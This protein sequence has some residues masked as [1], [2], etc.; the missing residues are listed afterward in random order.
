MDGISSSLTSML[1]G[2]ASGKLGHAL[3]GLAILIV[4]LIVVSFIA[5]FI[6]RMLGK[7]GFLQRSKQK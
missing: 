3:I 4:G 5:G 7:V 2:L 6:R 1:G